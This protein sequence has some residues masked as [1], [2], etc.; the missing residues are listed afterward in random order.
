MKSK[1][2]IEVQ[3]QNAQAMTESLINDL[4]NNR[5]YTDKD[6]LTSRLEY[7][8]KCLVAC[9]DRVQLEYED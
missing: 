5:P 8:K 7:I 2:Y 4:D 3:M 6:Y 1:S 9:L